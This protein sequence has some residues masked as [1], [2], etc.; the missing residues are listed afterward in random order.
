MHFDDNKDEQGN[1]AEED[2]EVLK[3]ENE[4]YRR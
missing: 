4:D 2:K 3:I 1:I